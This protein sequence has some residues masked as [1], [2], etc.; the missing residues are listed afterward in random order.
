[1]GR[2]FP[3]TEDVQREGRRGV[4]GGTAGFLTCSFQLASFLHV[5]PGINSKFSP[6]C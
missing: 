6:H 3:E 2:L 5:I 4:V 1:M